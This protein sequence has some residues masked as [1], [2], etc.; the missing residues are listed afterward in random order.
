MGLSLKSS[1]GAGSA[2]GMGKPRP[3]LPHV[4]SL[5]FGSIGDGY[6]GRHLVRNHR[7]S[8]SG[9]LVECTANLDT[10]WQAHAHA[11]Y[12]RVQ[13]TRTPSGLVE[14]AL[15]DVHPGCSVS[16]RCM[17]RATVRNAYSQAS[18]LL[19]CPIRPVPSPSSFAG[20]SLVPI[21]E[22]NETRN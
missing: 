8:V 6:W 3:S 5:R 2:A 20:Q 1:P 12:Q 17:Q 10:G 16:G 14:R 13:L 4:K 9:D 7:N 18:M 15:H 11:H 21:G 22:A 19:C